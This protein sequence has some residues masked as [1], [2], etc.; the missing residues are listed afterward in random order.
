MR[1]SFLL[2]KFLVIISVFTNPV[3]A[4]TIWTIGPMLHVNFGDEKTVCS[5]NME[6]AYWNFSGFPWSV[7][8]GLEFERKKFRIYTEGQTGIGVAGIASGPVFEINR[9]DKKESLGWQSSVWGN[10]YWGFDIRYRKIGGKSFFA[11]GTY[12]KIGFNGR[13]ENGEKIKSSNRSEFD[14]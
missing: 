14:D 9:V 2:I 11:P 10:Y 3:E 12:L 8:M 1:K 13:D 6:V 7:D 5:W 4:Q